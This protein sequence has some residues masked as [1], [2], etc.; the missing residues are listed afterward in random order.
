[1]AKVEGGKG[2]LVV[3]YDEEDGDGN[4]VW[5]WFGGVRGNEFAGVGESE[6]VG[7][8]AVGDKL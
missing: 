5:R 4:W 6:L 8:A 3:V 7:G 2:N 1:M